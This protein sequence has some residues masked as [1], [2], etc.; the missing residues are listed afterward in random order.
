M[1]IR[2]CTIFIALVLLFGAWPGPV[3]A[4]NANI[5]DTNLRAAVSGGTGQGKD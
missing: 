2:I 1:V 5:P 4:Q 3:N